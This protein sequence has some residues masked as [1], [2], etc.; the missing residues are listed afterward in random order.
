[1]LPGKSGF[2]VLGELRSHEATADLPVLMLTARGQK[3]DR[4]LALRAGADRCL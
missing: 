4:E 1:M 3:A 2:D